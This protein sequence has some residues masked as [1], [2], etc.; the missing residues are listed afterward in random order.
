MQNDIPINENYIKSLELHKI[1]AGI[2]EMLSSENPLEIYL[3]K[4]HL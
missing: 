1:Q 3:L 2:K 4:D